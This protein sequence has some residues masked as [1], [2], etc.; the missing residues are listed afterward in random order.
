[1]KA[2]LTTFRQF[3]RDLG[4]QKLRTLMTTFGI[5]WGTMSVVLLMGFGNGLQ[6]VQVK[7]MMGLGNR[8]S[9]IWPGITSKPWEGLPRGRHIRFTGDDVA[10]MKGSLTSFKAI[11]P[12][13]GRWNIPVK[14]KNN[15][16]LVYVGGVWPEFSEMRNLIPMEGGRFFNA[17]DMAEKRRVVFIGDEV[18]KDLFHS[19]NVVGEQ[20]FLND[21][22]FKI[23]GVLKRKKQNSSYN[24]R[25]YR[26]TWIPASTFRT[27]W[28][29]R[30]PNQIIVQSATVVQMAA[31]KKDIYRYMANKYK[32]DPDDSEALMIWDTTSS[33]IFFRDFFGAFQ[34]FLVVIGIM[35]LITGGIGVTNIMN[36]VLEER[37]KEIGI[38]M[39]LGA[40]KRFIM[41]QFLSETLLLTIIGGTLGFAFAALVIYIFPDSL[42]DSMG[43][44][45]I[46][47]NG[48][49]FS[50][51]VLGL[52]AL[53]SGFFPARRAAGM[54]PV[55][56]LKLF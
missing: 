29:Q 4:K 14:A 36:V 5:L 42:A 35:T 34:A 52:I 23:I 54:E 6:Q 38:K 56:A 18:A 28:T 20:L 47:I 40:K 7:R 3:F 53:I 48:A 11:S 33:L 32:F 15:T 8:I 26:Q 46:G 55:K 1:M 37:T 31:V 17:L 50:V 16:K 9:I 27:M 24:G 13:Y 22:P 2:V 45:T 12:E 41:T 49:L 10:R 25:D 44:P 21:V 30:Y 43:K 39:A 51:A 19:T